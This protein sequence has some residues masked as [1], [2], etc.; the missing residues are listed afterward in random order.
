[1]DDVQVFFTV[2]IKN[3][4][5]FYFR[6][7]WLNDLEHVLYVAVRTGII[8]TKF[9]LGQSLRSCNAFTADVGLRVTSRGDLV[10]W[11]FDRERL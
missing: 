9:E 4:P 2:Y 8:L 6:S 1:M 7:I 5:Y 3:L 11:P 10:L